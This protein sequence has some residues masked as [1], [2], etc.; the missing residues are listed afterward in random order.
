MKNEVKE[1]YVRLIIDRKLIIN[2][3]KRVEKSL[4]YEDMNKYIDVST[5]LS[6]RLDEVNN[7]ILETRREN[8]MSQDDI[9]ALDM[10]GFTHSELKEKLDRIPK[11]D[12]GISLQIWRKLFVERI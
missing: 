6:I 11:K 2:E 3:L 9:Y 7:K 12:K 10:Y 1:M 4:K 5:K 8:N